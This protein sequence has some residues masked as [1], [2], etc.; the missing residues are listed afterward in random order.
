MVNVVRARP[1]RPLSSIAK[2]TR[3]AAVTENETNTQRIFDGA[4]PSPTSRTAST[5]TWSPAAKQAVNPEKRGTKAAAHY[6]LDVP[7]PH[8]VG[9]PAPHPRLRPAGRHPPTTT[10]PFGGPFSTVL[11]ARRREADEYYATVIPASLGEDRRNVM[12]QALAGMLWSKQFYDYDVDDWLAEQA[13]SASRPRAQRGRNHDWSH[14]VSDDII[15]MPDKWEYPWYAAWDL[16]FHAI[17]SA[18]SIP[19]SRSSS[20]I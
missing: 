15:S 8:A 13:R 10:P 16:A 5:T 18:S 9:A 17:R 3:R 4:E 1:G 11:A 20:S 12:R 19:T 2:A 6:V 14:M 7:A